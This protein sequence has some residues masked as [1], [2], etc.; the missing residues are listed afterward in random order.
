[1]SSGCGMKRRQFVALGA[2]AGLGAPLI[3]SPTIELAQEPKWAVDGRGSVARLGVLTPDFDPVP[4]SEMAAMAPRGISIH[5]SRVA[6]QPGSPRTFAEP[7][8]VDTAV[9][10]LTQLRATASFSSRSPAAATCW[11]P[12]VIRPSVP[13]W[14]AAPERFRCCSPAVQRPKHS[15][16]WERTVSRWSI[17]P[18]LLKNSKH[19]EPVIFAVKDSRC[20][21]ARAFSRRDRSPKSLQP[22]STN[23][24]E[25]MFPA[26]ADAVFIG[27]N[28]LRA[29]GAIAALEKALDKPV[30]TANQVLLWQSLRSAGVASSVTE[31]GR[32]FASIESSLTTRVTP[33]SSRSASTSGS[34]PAPT[35]SSGPARPMR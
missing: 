32:I 10:L 13:G 9:E 35:T 23:G 20:S 16:A 12:K 27:G 1:M 31:Y 33:Q 26:V 6:R 30:L 34:A 28:G 2:A 24:R 29:I 25:L 15:V 18:G 7:P 21:V 8:H 22:K 14:R 4:E 3:R 5:G 19:K 11:G 17:R